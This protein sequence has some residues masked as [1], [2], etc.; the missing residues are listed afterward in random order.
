M[1]KELRAGAG[2][3]AAG[4][5]LGSPIF[6]A[7]LDAET[8]M[9]RLLAAGPQR[10]FRNGLTAWPVDMASVWDK[11]VLGPQENTTQVK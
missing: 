5:V 7:I 8:P 9:C 11:K 1:G 3:G 6:W 10:T 2:L 4:Q